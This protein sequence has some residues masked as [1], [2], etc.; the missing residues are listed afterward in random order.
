M[1]RVHGYPWVSLHSFYRL[2]QSASCILRISGRR[3]ALDVS[4]LSIL[5]LL[6]PY[7]QQIKKNYTMGIFST[8]PKAVMIDKYERLSDVT[9]VSVLY[10]L[11]C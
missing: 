4:R 7:Q 10:G 3:N 11:G 8:E 2:T 5:K 9:K 6:Q 1:P